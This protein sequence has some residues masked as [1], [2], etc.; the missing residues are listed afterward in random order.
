MPFQID[1]ITEVVDPENEDIPPR[2]TYFTEHNG[3][4]D[5]LDQL[6]FMISDM[7]NEAATYAWLDDDNSKNHARLRIK[8]SDPENESIT[9]YAYLYR[10]STIKDTVP[11]PYEMDFTPLQLRVDTK[12]YGLALHP[13]NNMVKDIEI[14]PPNGT[15]VDILDRQKIRFNG[16][17][18]FNIVTIQ[19]SLN[20]NDLVLFNHLEFTDDPIVRMIVEMKMS[21]IDTASMGDLFMYNDPKFYPYS[22]EIGGGFPLSTEELQ[23]REGIIDDIFIEV[24][25][26]RESWDL[27]SNATDMT[28]YNPYNQGI[29]IDG[30]LDVDLNN[31]V[32]VPIR[33]WTS[34]SGEQGTIL[35]YLAM[36]DTTWQSTELYYHDNS[37]GGTADQAQFPISDTGD[38]LQSFGDQGI[39]LIN[40]P[41]E[42]ADLLLNFKAFMLPSDFGYT[43]METLA[44]Q[45]ESRVEAS[46]SEEIKTSINNERSRFNVLDFTLHPNYPNPF[47]AGTWISFT[48]QRDSEVRLQI[49]DIQGRTVRTLIQDKETAGYHQV[50][51][52]GKNNSEIQVPTGIYFCKLSTGLQTQIQK[53]VYVK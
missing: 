23:L 19:G 42:V 2:W 13:E 27:N 26:L 25:A 39:L 16:V 32:D 29:P 18:G 52:N 7:G 24:H 5:S 49:L 11:R 47:N 37:A 44:A 4:L 3:I 12:Y 22:C 31:Q 53:L 28:F 46:T 15:G 10:S 41:T 6:V 14:K 17:I 45:Q 40:D 1:E 30:T 21:I 20:E 38:D 51:W 35:F 50:H 36:E 33:E 8:L 48:L 43:D 34:A 9:G